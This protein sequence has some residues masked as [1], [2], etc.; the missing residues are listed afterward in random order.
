MTNRQSIV[1]RLVTH[2][3]A[4]RLPASNG[5]TVDRCRQWREQENLGDLKLYRIPEPVTIAANS[6]KQVALLTRPGVRV[7][8]VWRTE[9]TDQEAGP[10]QSLM[11][12]RTRNR[13]DRGLGLP[14]PA[15]GRDPVPRL[16]GAAGPDRRCLDRG[17]GGGGKGRDRISARRPP[18]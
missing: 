8:I 7:D 17:S 2:S 9:V 12:V 11:T 18:R 10:L 4:P 6:Q 3:S 14:L 13:R 1:D 15:G 16:S 5:C